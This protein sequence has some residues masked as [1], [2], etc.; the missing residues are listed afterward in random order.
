MCVC[1]TKVLLLLLQTSGSVKNQQTRIGKR[2]LFV[3]LWNIWPLRW[4]TGKDTHRVLTGGLLVFSWQELQT[5]HLSINPTCLMHTIIKLL[6][7]S[8]K[9]CCATELYP[10]GEQITCSALVDWS[11]SYQSLFNSFNK[12]SGIPLTKG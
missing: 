8:L 12:R 5:C 1:M 10:L 7:L 6:H 4:S 11:N 2:T 3:A 9:N